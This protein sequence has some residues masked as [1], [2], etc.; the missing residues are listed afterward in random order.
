[1][2]I[3]TTIFWET[4]IIFEICVE[5]NEFSGIFNI[6]PQNFHVTCKNSSIMSYQKLYEII[7]K[8][9]PPG[10]FLMLMKIIRVEEQQA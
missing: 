2:I 6:F 1:M 8:G 4:F 7:I 3:I 5:K 10:V 9:S